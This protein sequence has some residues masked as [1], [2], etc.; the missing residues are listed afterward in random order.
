LGSF[1]EHPER[2]IAHSVWDQAEVFQTAGIRLLFDCGEDDTGTGAIADN[3]MLHAR[4]VELGVP[5]IWR[6]HAG[7]HSWDYWG[8]HLNEHLVFH[9]SA[10]IDD[11]P[12]FGR[13]QRHWYER[14]RLFHDENARFTLEPPER[15]VLVLL[16]PSTMEGLDPDLFPGFTVVNRGI[17]AD[18][19]GVAPRGTAHRLEPCVFDVRPDL[20]L[21]S[22][23]TNDIGD[24]SR[25][26]EPSLG[27]IAEQ[28]EQNLE[29]LRTRLPDTR[30]VMLACGPA[31]GR[32]AL[33]NDNIRA[34]NELLPGIAE[35]NGCILVDTHRILVDGE[36][37]LREDFTNDGL[38][39]NAAGTA[40]F[41]ER[42]N[43]GLA[44]AMAE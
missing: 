26:G 5:H 29:A 23:A 35:R 40:V 38:H 30:V 24:L 4:L 15:P 7:S 44:E 25:S 16:G 6:E 27:R 3:R 31:R 22:D 10:M 18:G 13:W 37:L 9:Q 1:D 33:I 19:V 32:Y 41:A 17:M 2:W 36:G 21:Y 11:T 34:F 12:G 43:A 39:L 8:D 42:I 28:Y 14:V 20:V